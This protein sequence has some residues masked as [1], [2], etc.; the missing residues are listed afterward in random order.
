MGYLD[1]LVKGKVQEVTDMLQAIR[2][3]YLTHYK[4]LAANGETVLKQFLDEHLP[5]HE[6]TSGASASINGGIKRHPLFEQGV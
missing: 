6:M 4:P 2:K 5:L 3:V 1:K